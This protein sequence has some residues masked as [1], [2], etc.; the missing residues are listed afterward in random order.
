[1]PAFLKCKKII[2]RFSSKASLFVLKNK[3]IK[4]HLPN[5][6][7]G[8]LPGTQPVIVRNTIF[9]FTIKIDGNE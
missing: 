6:I 2:I 3:R 5:K 1:M 9:S 8:T 7:P 4:I